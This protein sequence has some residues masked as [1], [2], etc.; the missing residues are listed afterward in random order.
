MTKKLVAV[1]N[2]KE[3]VHVAAN[4]GHLVRWVWSQ[5]DGRYLPIREERGSAYESQAVSVD[6]V[7]FE[8]AQQADI[9]ATHAQAAG[10]WGY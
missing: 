10:R 8:M 1:G 2:K 3:L 5:R 7:R 4:G 9:D 6:A